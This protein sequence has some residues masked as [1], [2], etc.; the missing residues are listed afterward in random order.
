[1]DQLEDNKIIKERNVTSFNVAFEVGVANFA[2]TLLRR[3]TCNLFGP[4][5]R[6]LSGRL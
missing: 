3:T 5:C 2:A 1:M 6:D 4:E